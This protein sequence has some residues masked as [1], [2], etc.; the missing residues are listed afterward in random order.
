MFP[1][2]LTS[3]CVPVDG[4]LHQ[5]EAPETAVEMVRPPHS[6]PTVRLSGNVELAQRADLQARASGVWAPER[7]TRS[8][9]LVWLS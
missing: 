8:E 2:V 6:W 7:S 1:T 5:E 9:H 4:G 3:G